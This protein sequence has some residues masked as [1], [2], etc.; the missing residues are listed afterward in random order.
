MRYFFFSISVAF[1]LAFAGALNTE[2]RTFGGYECTDDCSGHAAG[3]RWAAEHDID[4]EQ[5]CPE[6]DSQP[7][8]EG[9]LV[10]TQDSNRGYT[11]DD[12]GDPIEGQ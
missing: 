11:E 3:Y 1:A 2:A 8:H 10:H 5:Y 9:C 6:G 12:D 7:F 4:E